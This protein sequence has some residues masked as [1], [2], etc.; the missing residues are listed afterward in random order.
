MGVKCSQHLNEIFSLIFLEM[1]LFQYCL[2]VTLS[3]A[4]R[5]K[6]EGD[7]EKRMLEPFFTEQ[8]ALNS[9]LIDTYGRVSNELHKF[10]DFMSS[11]QLTRFK[12]KGKR[13]V[14]ISGSA[15]AENAFH[16]W[17]NEAILPRIST[18]KQMDSFIGELETIRNGMLPG[19]EFLTR[20]IRGTELA[21]AT[22][23]FI[24][25]TINRMGPIGLLLDQLIRNLAAN[26]PRSVTDSQVFKRASQLP[27]LLEPY[28][29]AFRDIMAR[30]R[31]RVNRLA[32]AGAEVGESIMNDPNTRDEYMSMISAV[33][34]AGS[35]EEIERIIRES[36]KTLMNR[37]QKVEDVKNIAN[38]VSR[39]VLKIGDKF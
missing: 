35:R 17:L 9:E 30:E 5:K 12:S 6:K 4:G 28:L 33:K 11:Q 26:I 21:G 13:M 19:N 2:L 31:V 25:E 23:A 14:P 18:F 29:H 24:E 20:T 36:Q 10:C 3:L 39:E 37:K 7:K 27:S 16:K 8:L 34:E 32:M 1:R 38:S 22:R 15:G